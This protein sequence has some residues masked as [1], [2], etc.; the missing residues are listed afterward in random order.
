[1]QSQEMMIQ[2]LT[3]LARNVDDLQVSLNRAS[4]NILSPVIMERTEIIRQQVD[5]LSQQIS[6]YELD[7]SKMRGLVEIGQ[8]LNSSL[9]TQVV[10]QNVMDTIIQLTQAERGFLMLRDA[11]GEFST[12]IARNWEQDSVS[13]NEEHISHSIIRRVMEDG[14]PVLTTNATE[15]PRFIHQESV[16]A[17]NLRSI[18]CVPL[19]VKDAIVG[20]I[21]TDHRI[22]TGKFS[23]A[24]RETL[25]AFGNQAAI[26]IENSRLYAS[27]SQN[28]SEVT[29]L[30]NLLGS[31]FNSITS[32]VITT[33]E[34]RKVIFCNPAARMV[35]G[36]QPGLILDRYLE[37]HHPELSAKLVP[38]LDL[39]QQQEEIISGLELRPQLPDQGEMNYRFA[40]TPLRDSREQ[41]VRGLT[42]VVE[43][44]TENL[45]LKARQRLFER[46]VS[47]IVIQQLDPDGIRLGGSRAL[48]SVLF[49][50]I[51][52]FTSLG[53]SVSPETLVSVLNCYL[54]TAAEAVLELEGT[55]DKFL[56]DSVMAW[57]NAPILLGD[58]ALRAVKAAVHIR[59]SLPSIYCQLSE[60]FHLKFSIGIH[61]GEAVL[62]MIGS[63]KRMEYTAIGDSVNIAK[64]IQENAATDQILISED[65]YLLVKD[66][67]VANK[68]EPFTVRGRKE[69]V[70]VYEVLALI[71]SG[72]TSV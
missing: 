67:I 17:Y 65:T 31:V 12:R 41:K 33:D 46:M 52:G 32:G 8:V 54:S 56:G 53:E 35:L 61:T 11:Q 25:A 51:S 28:L 63:E 66:Q 16:V 22:Q 43:D 1:M 72:I 55:I 19:M 44:Q 2:Q 70:Q 24:D 30:K 4:V 62:G 14:Q 47:P 71:D 58:H 68:L 40:L 57:F 5:Q 39:V 36:I 7:M 6:R 48:I 42:I 9:D 21:Y 29:G 3:T 49:A 13:T 69:P 45:K 26:A 20:V 18:L 23:E 60:E 38:Y 34:R 37:K 59:Q 15:D 64:R 50:D 27:I 10:L